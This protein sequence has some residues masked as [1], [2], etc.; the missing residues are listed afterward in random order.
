VSTD[1]RLQ[2][3]LLRVV[4]FLGGMTMLMRSLLLLFFFFFSS[5]SFIRNFI[6]FINESSGT[7]ILGSLYSSTVLI[8]RYILSRVDRS[9]FE[10]LPKPVSGPGI[11]KLAG[12]LLARYGIRWSC[13]HTT[14]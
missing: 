11:E 6:I 4:L 13:F 1:D 10:P 9:E 7:R 12:C 3:F 2:C 14:A 8:F 5:S